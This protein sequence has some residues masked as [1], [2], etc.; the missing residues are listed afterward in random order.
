M[1][2]AVW[3]HTQ[4]L[5]RHGIIVELPISYR[6]YCQPL[7]LTPPTCAWICS[8]CFFSLSCNSRF[9]ASR[10]DDTCRGSSNFHRGGQL[11]SMIK[12]ML[13]Y[14]SISVHFLEWL[15]MIPHGQYTHYVRMCECQQT[16]NQNHLCYSI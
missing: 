7:G 2:S 10:A 15:H 11:K 16:A 3:W 8:L 1:F 9:F 14:L 6:E 13:A 5:T 12:T 4:N